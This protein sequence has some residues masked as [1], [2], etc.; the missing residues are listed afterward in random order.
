MSTDLT[1]GAQREI[2]TDLVLRAFERVRWPRVSPKTAF[3]VAFST[4]D[5]GPVII[6][7]NALRTSRARRRRSKRLAIAGD[8]QM[9]RHQRWLE[10]STYE[11]GTSCWRVRPIVYIDG[12]LRTAVS[13][14]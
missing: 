7:T 4:S 13:V 14:A 3:D 9:E 11:R 5:L 6:S 2:Q 12:G 10:R 8:D 1:A